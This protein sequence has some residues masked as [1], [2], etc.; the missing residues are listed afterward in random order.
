MKTTIKKTVIT[1][2][3][4]TRPRI[5]ILHH[6]DSY[7]APL[8]EHFVTK[9]MADVYATSNR[10]EA[11]ALLNKITPDMIITSHNLPA[12]DGIDFLRTLNSKFSINPTTMTIIISEEMT[13]PNVGI[14][15]IYERKKVRSLLFEL[16]RIFYLKELDHQVHD[17]DKEIKRLT[18]EIKSKGEQDVSILKKMLELKVPWVTPRL[19]ASSRASK[20][21]AEHMDMSQK[22][23][24]E[25]A[26]AAALSDIGKIFLP[27]QK[28]R[29]PMSRL[30]LD[31]FNIIRDAAYHAEAILCD[32]PDFEFITDAIKYQFENFNGTGFPQGLKG[33][34]IPKSSRILR[35]VNYF[36]ESIDLPEI[37]IP[38]LTIIKEIEER[39]DILFDPEVVEI[40]KHYLE[41]EGDTFWQ[42][43]LIKL[44]LDELNTGMVIAQDLV[45]RNGILLLPSESVLTERTLD[46]VKS[47]L[48]IYETGGGV[49]IL[50]NP[51]SK[52]KIKHTYISRLGAN[53]QDIR[54]KY[55]TTLYYRDAHDTSAGY[56]ES[57]LRDISLG[58]TFFETYEPY[59][60]LSKLEVRIFSPEFGKDKKN[61][62]VQAFGVIRWVRKLS[63]NRYHVGLQF[64]TIDANDYE[65]LKTFMQKFQ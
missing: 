4:I 64:D 61:N 44:P 43:N 17:L 14:N 8:K 29:K 33:L 16:D 1:E 32:I 10:K 65:K 49:L 31:D 37:N 51:P 15:V 7:L 45:N 42:P 23:A 25:T 13:F 9:L 50:K 12:L 47:Q 58:G 59:P 35:I 18:Q 5:V 27:K 46:H 54:Y 2:P 57:I 52:N 34:K 3:I 41:E 38:D 40:F 22:E 39:S 20:F 56:K 30:G 53:R 24:F 6:V 62:Y 26:Q 55:A 21:I 63:H 48:D 36:R 19:P 60:L 11:E 28:A